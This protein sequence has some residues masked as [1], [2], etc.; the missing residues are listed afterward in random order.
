LQSQVA[1]SG[2]CQG[3]RNRNEILRTR[4][5]NREAPGA[6]PST[7]REQSAPRYWGRPGYGPVVE[8]IVKVLPERIEGEGVLLRRW[9]VDDAE[10][11]GRAVG[12][13]ADHL[14]PWMAFMAEEPQ[15]LEQRE[16]MLR[17]RELEWS[18]GGD[19]MLAI[20]VDD[21]VAGSCGLHRRGGPKTGIECVEIHHDKA[22]PR[23]PA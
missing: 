13:S 17:D 20:I 11:P 2:E 22:N 9:R 14:R 16:Q 3:D 8:R 18:Q 10:A 23:A 1:R 5:P 4:V 21:A 15:T 19:V 12:E 7:R 6:A